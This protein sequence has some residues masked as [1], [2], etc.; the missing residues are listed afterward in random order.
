MTSKNDG[1]N[2]NHSPGLSEFMPQAWQQLT[3]FAACL[4]RVFL[5]RLSTRPQITGDVSF[6]VR[7][8]VEDSE[9]ID[10]VCCFLLRVGG[11]GVGMR[12]CKY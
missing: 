3:C 2:K 6:S 7:C 9:V 10:L 5:L 11:G 4:S 1:R 8:R 12:R